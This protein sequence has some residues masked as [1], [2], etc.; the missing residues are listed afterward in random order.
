MRLIE[1]T[2]VPAES[3]DILVGRGTMLSIEMYGTASTISVF[4]QG[5][6]SKE[7][8]YSTTPVMDVSVYDTV[9][10]LTTKGGIYVVDISPF[11]YVQVVVS[12]IS[13]GSITVDGKVM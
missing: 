3:Q 11:E 12:A 1:N 7:A 8:P 5:K 13:D 2:T 10:T 4:V 9:T 6:I